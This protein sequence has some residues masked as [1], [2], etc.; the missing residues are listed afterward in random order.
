MVTIAHRLPYTAVN[1][2]AYEQYKILAA[3][4]NTEYRKQQWNCSCRCMVVLCSDGMSGITAATA[5]YPLDL[6][7]T[8]LRSVLVMLKMNS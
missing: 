1:F 3:K 7:R 6:I 5:T 8:R 2:Y 4:V